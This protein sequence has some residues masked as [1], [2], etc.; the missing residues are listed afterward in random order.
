MIDISGIDN[1]CTEPGDAGWGICPANEGCLRIYMNPFYD[2]LTFD[3]IGAAFVTLFQVVIQQNWTG[4]MYLTWDAFSF[5]SWP[6]FIL[7]NLFGPMFAVQLFLVVVANQYS[8]ARA[9]QREMEKA[10]VE[11]YEVK[12]GAVTANL[13]HV[14]RTGNQLAQPCDSYVVVTVD[15]KKKQTRVIRGSFVPE[16]NEYFVF[17]VSSAASY[18][19]IEVLNWRRKGKH[20]LIGSLA[21]PVGTLDQC[22]EGTDR[23]YEMTAEDSSSVEGT[24]RIRTQWRSISGD[25]WSPLPE[26]DDEDL[27]EEEDAE[28]DDLSLAQRIQAVVRSV[29][30]SKGLTVMSVL[31]ICANMLAMAADHSC[32][33]VEDGYCRY[34]KAQL[35]QANLVFT[36]FFSFEMII[37]LWGL[38]VL[39]YFKEVSNVFDC[40]VVIISLVE[41]PASVAE[42]RCYLSASQRTVKQCDNAGGALSVL[43][44]FRVVRI[45]RLGKL[46]ELFPQ[47]RRQIKVIT[48]TLGAVSSLVVLILMY[49]VIFAILGMSALGGHSV[50]YLRT[51]DPDN[52]PKFRLGN[53]VRVLVPTNP[54]MIETAMFVNY[55]PTQT[56]NQYQVY[57][58]AP[59]NSLWPL[60]N[61]TKEE[62]NDWEL[63]GL[64]WLNAQELEPFQYPSFVSSAK[65][66]IIVGI[67]PRG[68]FDTFY[69]ALISVF[70]IFTTS[71]LGDVLYP[72]IRGTGMYI[73]LY[74]VAQILLGNLL[75]FNLFTGIIITGFQETK[76]ALQKEEQENQ[77][78]R[79]QDK[80]RRAQSLARGMSIGSRGRKSSVGTSL[81]RGMSIGSNMDGEKCSSLEV[82]VEKVKALIIGSNRV[83]AED[84]KKSAI[85]PGTPAGAESKEEEQKGI[86]HMI[87]KH[88]L[89]EATILLSIVVSSASLAMQRPGMS[90]YEH[91]L[92]D[93]LDVTVGVVF[94]LE[95]SL[96]IAGLGIYRYLGSRWNQVDFF[97]VLTTWIDLFLSWFSSK[98]KILQI[99]K[100]SFMCLISFRCQRRLVFYRL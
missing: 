39:S 51:Q 70:Q 91:W 85:A 16:W 35:E 65:E 97:L 96:K 36:S 100:H 45:L 29:A 11:L 59:S 76:D 74:F 73:A 87:V 37:K 68:N 94:L 60:P 23:W 57:R 17:L 13:P 81:G 34:F 84:L 48:R 64:I 83:S 3:Y 63:N 93:I 46:V 9:H 5:W 8:G 19:R 33:L 82:L 58:D 15:E 6:F 55:D 99:C 50:E 44:S 18:A 28:D 38:G 30:E 75:L 90:S 14:A 31:V 78:M 2:A 24:V 7:L 12:I 22:E 25:E 98:V 62:I 92:S 66:A 88:K 26:V 71:D 69:D 89:F 52:I 47:I 41:L 53:N 49:M 95:A 1:L 86:C 54:F 32:D 42:I 61:L 79:D 20:E 40:F 21:I 80:L 27:P 72:A 67:V 10:A 4:I 56:S 43:R 77:K